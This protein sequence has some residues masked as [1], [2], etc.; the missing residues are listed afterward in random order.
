M[1]WAA[2]EVVTPPAVTPIS[3]DEAAEHLRLD[4]EGERATVELFIASAVAH[5]EGEMQRSLIKRTLRAISD[6][7]RP[8]RHPRPIH[9]EWGLPMGPVSSIVSVDGDDTVPT[10]LIRHAGREFARLP[11]DYDYA[12]DDLR[13]VYHAGYG[14]QPADVPADIRLALL[15]HVAHLFRHREAATERPQHAV[16]HGLEAIYAR[17]RVGGVAT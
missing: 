14:D 9:V 6:L 16:A 5:A 3:F 2:T 4:G 1:Q 12:N 17:H 13:I 8:K 11:D 7:G 15:M 10:Q